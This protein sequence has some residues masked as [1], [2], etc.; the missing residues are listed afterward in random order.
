MN[1]TKILMIVFISFGG[2]LALFGIGTFLSANSAQRFEDKFNENAIEVQ[3][4]VDEVKKI[5]DRFEGVDNNRTEIYYETRV[6]YTVNGK[7][8]IDIAISDVRSDRYSNDVGSYITVYCLEDNPTLIKHER[9]HDDADIILKGLGI[10][11]TICGV[12][13]AGGVIIAVKVDDYRRKKAIENM[14]NGYK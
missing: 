14:K 9:N 12:T 3:A 2:I 1:G 6:S 4:Y 11:L 8:Y 7:E 5:V 10:G 13:L